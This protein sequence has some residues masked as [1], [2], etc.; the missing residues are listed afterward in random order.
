METAEL[1]DPGRVIAE[2]A[3]NSF[4][5]GRSSGPA[6]TAAAE[7]VLL[8]WPGP[9]ALVASTHKV[10]IT[11]LTGI[12]PASGEGIILRAGAVHR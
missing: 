8:A 6:Q 7:V 3:F 12:V 1:T 11:V 5:A 2:S 4:L 9:G 10:N